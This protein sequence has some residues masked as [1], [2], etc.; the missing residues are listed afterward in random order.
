[1]DPLNMHASPG[2]PQASPVSLAAAG[3]PSALPF[4]RRA[5]GTLAGAGPGHPHA[6]TVRKVAAAS[7]P[8]ALPLVMDLALP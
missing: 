4:P 1:M 3:E 2:P 5:G 8:C 6:G 7:E